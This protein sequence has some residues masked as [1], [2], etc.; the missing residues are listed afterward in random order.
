MR[1]L[2]LSH[3]F[4]ID[5]IRFVRLASHLIY[6]V[7]DYPHTVK[8]GRKLFHIVNVNAPVKRH[9]PNKRSRFQ[10]TSRSL[11]FYLVPFF[12]CVNYLLAAERCIFSCYIY[13]SFLCVAFCFRRVFSEPVFRGI[14]PLNGA[15]MGVPH[16]CG[17]VPVICRDFLY[18]R[19]EEKN[20]FK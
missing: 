9:R 4:G 5:I 20:K 3:I 7:R 11:L 10:M 16:N 15:I 12:L 14:T 6:I 2:Y 19:N 18:L 1:L 13:Q 8:Q 17:K